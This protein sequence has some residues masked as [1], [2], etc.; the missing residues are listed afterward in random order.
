MLSFRLVKTDSGMLHFQKDDFAVL[1]NIMENV[2]S[3]FTF[4][5]A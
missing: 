5:A 1:A 2:V 3:Y 4:I